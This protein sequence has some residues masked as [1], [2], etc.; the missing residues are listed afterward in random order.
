MT[1]IVP[2][3]DMEAN[4]IFSKT[5]LITKKQQFLAIKILMKNSVKIFANS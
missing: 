2:F 5:I 4:T 1:I 3:I